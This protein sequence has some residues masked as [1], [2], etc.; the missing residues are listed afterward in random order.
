M[1]LK[2]AVEKADAAAKCCGL[3]RQDG[4]VCG[5]EQCS[6]EHEQAYRVQENGRPRKG[7]CIIM[8]LSPALDGHVGLEPLAINELIARKGVC[9]AQDQG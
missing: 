5:E 2:L 8:L 9:S 6:V 1:G 7:L 4:L 3:A